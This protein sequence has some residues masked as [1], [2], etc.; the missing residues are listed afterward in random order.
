M[1]KK[2]LITICFLAFAFIASAQYSPAKNINGDL[3]VSNNMWVRDTADIRYVSADTVASTSGFITTIYNT[4]LINNYVSTAKLR[5]TDTIILNK[6][7]T[8][9]YSDTLAYGDSILLCASKVVLDGWISVDTAGIPNG[10]A[11]FLV[12]SS[13][14]VS[15]VYTPYGC[16]AIGTATVGKISV[17]QHGT[18]VYIKNT[19]WSKQRVSYEIKTL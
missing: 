13:G 4:T 16:V 7:I 9:N 10:K 2:I 5:A 6:F 15:Q 3:N 12:A 8:T 14:A 1:M 17:I 11:E 18:S 19:R